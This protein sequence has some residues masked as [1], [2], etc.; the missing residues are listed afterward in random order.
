VLR[1]SRRTA[2]PL[3]DFHDEDDV[4]DEGIAG[5]GRRKDLIALALAMVAACAIAVNALFLQAGPHPAPIFANKPAPVPAIP[6]AP[7]RTAQPSAA[8]EPLMR[9]ALPR[10]RPV[11][12]LPATGETG[13]GGRSPSEVI[14]E[15][16][17]ELISRGFYDGV[18]DGLYGPKTDA[19]IRDF[20]QAAGLKPAAEPDE[21]LLSQIA[22]SH[23]KAQTT[24]AA[25]PRSDPIAE[26][27]APMP[28]TR[29]VAVQ[30]ALADFGYGQIKPSGIVDTDTQEAISRF[31]RAKKMPVTGQL[32]PRLVRELSAMTGRPLE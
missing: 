16:Q 32:S 9:M 25:A 19:A 29:I 4:H 13:F 21:N 26:L 24:M 28:S 15:I 17:K 6:L 31:E 22:R 11:E 2:P 12:T 5:S 27:I 14:T 8:A 7:A 30:R 18:P 20:E 1:V 3:I 10:P 23:V